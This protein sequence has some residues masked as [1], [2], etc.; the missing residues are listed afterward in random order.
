MIIN[1]KH[2]SYPAVNPDG[3]DFPSHFIKE[4]KREH[5][6]TIELLSDGRNT[7]YSIENPKPGNWYALAYIKWVDP[8]TERVEQQGKY[9]SILF[10]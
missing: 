4:G 8:R 2:G 3:Y 1:L 10:L 6:H 5:V 9:L 7:T